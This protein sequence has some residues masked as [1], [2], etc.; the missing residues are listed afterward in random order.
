MAI[1]SGLQMEET[2]TN[3]KGLKNLALFGRD[4]AVLAWDTARQ[5]ACVTSGE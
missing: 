2:V 5:P 3:E 4:E 1:G